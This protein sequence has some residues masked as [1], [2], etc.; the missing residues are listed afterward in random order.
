[1]ISPMYDAT[2]RFPRARHGYDPTT[3]DEYVN[4][5][6]LL[7]RSLQQEVDTLRA[8]L[9]E[10]STQLTT[11]RQQTTALADSS[12]SPRAVTERIAKMLRIAVDEVS[13]MQFEARVEAEQLIVNAQAE[14]EAA[15]AKG[16]QMLAELTSRQHAIE[17]EYAEVMNKAR[18]EAARIT[19]QAV[20]EAEEQ[21]EVEALRRQQAED[22]LNADLARA[23]READARIEELLRAAA[24]DCELRLQDAKNESERRLRVAN[25]Q[26][27]RRLTDARRTL[28]EITERRI[29][30]LEQLMQVHGTLEGIPVILE[31]AYREVNVS[32]DSGLALTNA[33]DEGSSSVMIINE[34]G[35]ED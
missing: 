6:G 13:D 4:E 27:D 2:A 8:Q 23:R 10:S 29:S 33:L 24:Q 26:I 31:N 5:I 28:D 34:S 25:E 7:Q 22:E 1:M 9:N 11:L 35:E 14:M 18:E 20:N 12:P 3:V 32:P 17:A 21:R 16:R 19:A 30:V 15:Q